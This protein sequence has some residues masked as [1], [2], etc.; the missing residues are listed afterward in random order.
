LE[1]ELQRSAG[2]IRAMYLLHA[3]NGTVAFSIWRV[4]GICSAECRLILSV[5]SDGVSSDVPV[6]GPFRIRH[7]IIIVHY[8][9]YA[10]F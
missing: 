1:S 10:A 8:I 7:T 2:K 6:Y 3:G 4:V 5:F 9:A